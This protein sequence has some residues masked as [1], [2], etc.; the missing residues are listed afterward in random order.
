MV[1]SGLA[2]GAE[3]FP[4]KPIHIVVGYAPGGAADLV[5]R[6][7]AKGLGER[8]GQQV[9]VDNRPGAGGF[10]GNDLVAKSAPDGHTLLLAN[11]SFAYIP[12][13]FGKLSLDTK[14][15]FYPVALVATTQNLL[16]IH[17]SVPARNVRELIALARA[18]PGRLNYASG[19]VGGS[20]HLA[21]ELLKSI[22]G[23]EI[24]HIAYKGNAPSITDLI[25]GQVDLTIAPI[26]ALLPFANSG[27]L[28]AL[29]TTGASRSPIYPNLPTIAEGGVPGYEAGSWYGYMAPAKTSPAVVTRLSDEMLRLLT[30]P[31]FVQQLVTVIGAEPSGLPQDKFAQFIAHETG[32]WGKVIRVAGI[33]AD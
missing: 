16:V 19:G 24:V 11:S 29:A 2:S 9:V 5:S 10:I 30:L 15:D 6:L 12:S 21:T 25:S 3:S 8:L 4:S 32:K 33:K 1:I 13:M 28:K 20:T 23:T 22:T 7:V 27:R 14:R 17:P 31:E 26:P 18:N